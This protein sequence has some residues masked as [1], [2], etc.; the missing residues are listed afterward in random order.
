MPL[1]HRTTPRSRRRWLEPEGH[2]QRHT[3]KPLPPSRVATT[4]RTR[5]RI[6]T[7]P[8]P[9]MRRT[10]RHITTAGPRTRRSWTR[11]QNSR[12]I[13]YPPL[14]LLV[15]PDPIFPRGAS[16]ARSLKSRRHDDDL[17]PPVPTH[18]HHIQKPSP[19]NRST[20]GGPCDFYVITANYPFFYKC[21]PSSTPPRQ[22]T[23]RLAQDLMATN[24]SS[25]FS[26]EFEGDGLTFYSGD[27]PFCEAID[28]W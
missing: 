26:D 11:V 2:E 5:A 19:R 16:L 10:D 7:T 20:A 21:L 25:S 9:S 24:T 28:L 17:S 27:D 15:S 23:P 3:R 12:H 4:D 6:I 18:P 1:R 13:P 22:T 8:A 14:P